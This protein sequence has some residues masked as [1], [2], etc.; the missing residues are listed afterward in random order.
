MINIKHDD[1]Q[2]KSEFEKMC[3][4][5]LEI[6]VSDTMEHISSGKAPSKMTFVK[7]KSIEAR[8]KVLC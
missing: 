5:A 8:D 6:D 1:F 7:F 2:L 4:D 3:A